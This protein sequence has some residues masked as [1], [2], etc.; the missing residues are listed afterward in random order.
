[1][2]AKFIYESM[3]FKR[4]GSP[5]E[6]LGLGVNLEK[7]NTKSWKILEFIKSK[8]DEGGVGL[9]E[10]QEYIYFDL[11]KAPWGG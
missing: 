11:N 6:S 3:K 5:A 8:E 4:H 9:K 10:I 2:K 7:K 1:M